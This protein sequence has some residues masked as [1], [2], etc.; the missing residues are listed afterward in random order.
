[1]PDLVDGCCSRAAEITYCL[2]RYIESD[3]IALLEKIRN[4]LGRRLNRDRYTSSFRFSI[5][6]SLD[7]PENC[8]IRIGGEVT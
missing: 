1:M 5:P 7:A 4:C 3:L 6:Y 2:N 8:T